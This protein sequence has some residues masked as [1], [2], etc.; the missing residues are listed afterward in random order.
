MAWGN[1]GEGQRGTLAAM[2]MISVLA[3]VALTRLLIET[4]QGQPVG[5]KLCAHNGG[6]G[7]I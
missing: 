7:F 2:A 5:S 6:T 4:A 1:S 3:V